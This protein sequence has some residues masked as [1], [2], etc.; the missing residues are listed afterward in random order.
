MATIG[1]AGLT[2]NADIDGLLTGARWQGAVTYSFP[3]IAGIYRAGY[4]TGEPKDP[5]FSQVSA[6]QQ[7]VVDKAAH[8]IAAFTNLDISH[9]ARSAGADF[10][11]AQSA[12]ANPTAYTYVLGA[13]DNGGDIWFG[14]A[15]DWRD[16]K[17]GDYFYYAHIHEFAHALGLKH[18]HETSGR[19]P[20]SCRPS[21]MPSNSR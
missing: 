20:R 6:A 11:I 4:G 15:F 3:S 5:S 14:T 18:G 19:L 17:V 1:T 10:L 12:I 21:A 9:Q 7:A 8:D 13:S 2:G 16:P